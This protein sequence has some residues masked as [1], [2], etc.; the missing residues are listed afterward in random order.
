MWLVLLH[1]LMC[2]G[3]GECVCCVRACMC[4]CVSLAVS[5]CIIYIWVDMYIVYKALPVT[6]VVCKWYN[7]GTSVDSVYSLLITS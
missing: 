1:K 2:V 3:V 6:L 5:F 4:V 7:C